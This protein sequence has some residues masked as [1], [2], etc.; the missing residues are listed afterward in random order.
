[1][2]LRN[3]NKPRQQ[4]SFEPLSDAHLRT[5]Q[6]KEVEQAVSTILLMYLSL[7]TKHYNCIFLTNV[8]VESVFTVHRE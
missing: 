1:M 7:R 4:T 6:N 8:V 2:S 5:K 3:R